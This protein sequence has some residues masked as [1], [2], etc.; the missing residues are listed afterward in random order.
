MCFSSHPSSLHTLTIDPSTQC[1]IRHWNCI[2][3]IIRHWNCIE[4]LIRHWNFI[5]FLIRHFIETEIS[6]Q[7]LKL[8]QISNQTLTLYLIGPP[9]NLLGCSSMS[10]VR[11]TLAGKILIQRKRKRWKGELQISEKLIYA[12]YKV[13]SSKMVLFRLNLEWPKIEVPGICCFLLVHN[14]LHVYML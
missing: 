6:H 7:T 14:H 9:G 10:T 5:D 8:Y 13:F 4:F 2:E 3:F 11:P 1:I 12:R